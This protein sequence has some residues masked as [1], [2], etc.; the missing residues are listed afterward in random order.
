VLLAI[1]SCNSIAQSTAMPAADLKEYLDE[2]EKFATL[3]PADTYKVG[4]YHGYLLSTLETL[5]QAGTACPSGRVSV[6]ELAVAVDPRVKETIVG[7]RTTAR[8]V[9]TKA[10]TDAFPCGKR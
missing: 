9:I 7:A 2:S 6:V 5:T 3:Q 1:Y 10:I 8:A 4:W